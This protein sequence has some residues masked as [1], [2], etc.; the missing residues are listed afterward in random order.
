MTETMYALRFMDVT[1]RLLL[2][3][4]LGGT[5]GLE[6]EFKRR[7]TGLRTHMLVCLGAAVTTLTSQ[8]LMLNMHYYTDISRLGAQVI[9][10][11][12]FVGT[13]TIIVSRRQRIRGL[14]TAAGLWAAAIIGMA[15][16]AGF[17]LA[18]VVTTML[19]MFIETVFSALEHRMAKNTR[20]YNLML[21]YRSKESLS[22]IFDI[23]RE[24]NVNVQHVQITHKEKSNTDC[25]FA[26]FFLKLSRKHKIEQ[27]METLSNESDIVS[28]KML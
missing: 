5:I 9:S 1:G 26:I 27:L 23:Y 13:G 15:V 16:G 2:A 11:I 4:I 28:I 19:I 10:G 6:R 25:E 3:V 8:Y 17:Y 18:G 24:L 20:E 7:P 22:R 21:E 12:G 14:T